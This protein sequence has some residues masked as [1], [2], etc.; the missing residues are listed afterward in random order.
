MKNS[1]PNVKSSTQKYTAITLQIASN[2]FIIS[3]S[4]H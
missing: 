4:Y 2:V 3:N 1:Y